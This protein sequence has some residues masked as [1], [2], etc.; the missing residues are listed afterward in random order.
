MI[1]ERIASSEEAKR[2]RKSKEKPIRTH[3]NSNSSSS[4]TNNKKINLSD[5]FMKSH[6]RTKITTHHKTIGMNC[7]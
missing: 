3:T 1:T 5:K 4:S 7:Y 6:L 2:E